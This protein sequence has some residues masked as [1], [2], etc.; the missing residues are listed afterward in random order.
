[1]MNNGDQLFLCAIL[2]SF[3]S[4]NTLFAR[5]LFLKSFFRFL[6]GCTLI[7]AFLK[8]AWI[9]SGFSISERETCC[10]S[11]H[12]VCRVARRVVMLFIVACPEYP[13]SYIIWVLLLFFL[14]VLW[15]QFVNYLYL[16]LIPCIARQK[17]LPFL[18]VFRGQTSF[19]GVQGA[20]K[21]CLRGLDGFMFLGL[22]QWDQDQ[23]D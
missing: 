20:F 1:M 3:S 6:S 7:T 16:F 8:R 5:Y 22:S 14:L 12:I 4:S 2:A 23:R 10:H 17:H 9:S 18:I 21:N 19:W 15:Q 13:H 11:G